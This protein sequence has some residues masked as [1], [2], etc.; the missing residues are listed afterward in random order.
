MFS[1]GVEQ[2]HHLMRSCYRRVSWQVSVV[3]IAVKIS[4]AVREMPLQPTKVS[5]FSADPTSGAANL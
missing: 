5:T 2:G 1:T 3:E 4:P